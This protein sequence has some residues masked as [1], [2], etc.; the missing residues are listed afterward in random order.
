MY[1]LLDDN[2]EVSLWIDSFIVS[3]IQAISIDILS[4]IEI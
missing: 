1:K 2:F 4:I 3:Y